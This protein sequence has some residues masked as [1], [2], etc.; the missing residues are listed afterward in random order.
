VDGDV[1]DCGSVE[2]RRASGRNGADDRPKV[3]P[4]RRQ[5]RFSLIRVA[6]PTRSRR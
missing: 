4:G 2:S 3:G 5:S 1:A 6:L